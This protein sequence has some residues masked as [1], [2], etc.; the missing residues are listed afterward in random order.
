[1]IKDW[2]EYLL[3]YSGFLVSRVPPIVARQDSSPVLRIDTEFIISDLI[4]RKGN[5]P[6]TFLQI[7]AFDGVSGDPIHNYIERHN[8]KGLF[9]ELQKG[10][11]EKLKNI[12]SDQENVEFLHAAIGEDYGTRKLYTIDKPGAEDMPA[13]AAQIASFDREV[14][15]SHKWAI[16]N[17]EN[18]I[19][20][21]Q[22]DCV[23][24]KEVIRRYNLKMVDVIQIDVEGFDAKVIDMI[25]FD[26]ISPSVVRF[27][28][29]HLSDFE[30]KRSLKKLINNK[31]KI[32]K[33]ND[34][35]VAY[36]RPST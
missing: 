21:E 9:V 6:I 20:Y 4:E 24:L 35:T 12:Y 18:R 34:D 32:H 29:I 31:Y 19:T 27:E 2:V 15:I 1:M 33:E 5:E 36:L 25:D 10:P 17:I 13:W 30:Y 23:P 26:K 28:H 14:V 7:G 16:P 8:W 11:F 3:A 22:V